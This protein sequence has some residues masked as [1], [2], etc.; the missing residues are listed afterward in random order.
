MEQI[1]SFEQYRELAAEARRLPN[2]CTNWYFLPEAVR[3][4]IERGILYLE[5]VSGGILLLEKEP[6]FLRCYFFLNSAAPSERIKLP[7]PGVAELVYQNKMTP[8]QETQAALLKGMGFSLGRESGRLSCPE[9]EA[10]EE[11]CGSVKVASSES[12]IPAICRLIR[13]TFDPRYAFIS[14]E[15][16]TALDLHAGNIF[17]IREGET[18]AGVLYSECAKGVASIRQLAVDESCRGR[19]LG[20]QLI[21]FYHKQYRGKVRTFAHWVDL[22]NAP[23]IRLYRKMGYSPDGRHADEYII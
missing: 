7:A 16:Q 12:D 4:K 19:G 21:S 13:S 11:E 6:E 23:A 9:S 1:K 18:L 20:R 2:L 3:E 10:L 22:N 14:D 8:A 17:Q 15:K 5:K